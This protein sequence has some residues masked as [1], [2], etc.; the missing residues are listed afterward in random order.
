[1]LNAPNFIPD[2]SEISRR[3]ELLLWMNLMGWDI[4]VQD[5]IMYLDNP[6]PEDVRRLVYQHGPDEAL[7][8]IKVFVDDR[9]IEVPG[10]EAEGGECSE[11]DSEGGRC[12]VRDSEEDEDG[13]W[14]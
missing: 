10:P 9:P 2:R 12:L 13:V 7:R 8:L 14:L 11:I 5:S 6:S 1:M 4:Y 3:C